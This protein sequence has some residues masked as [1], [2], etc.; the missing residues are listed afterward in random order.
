MVLLCLCVCVW[1]NLHT[2]VVKVAPQAT[3]KLPSI[4][5]LSH[6]AIRCVIIHSYNSFSCFSLADDDR[7]CPVDSQHNLILIH[8]FSLSFALVLHLLSLF[9]SF[10]LV[11]AYIWLTFLSSTN[12]SL[13]VRQL[14]IYM[15]IKLNNKVV[16]FV[17]VCVCL[18]FVLST[19]SH[20][21][22]GG[23]N[24]KEPMSSSSSSSPPMYHNNGAWFLCVCLWFH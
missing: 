8:I 2:R 20:V 18:Y 23:P 6:K 13:L 17:C 3:N 15:S 12:L 9:L 16:L 11:T 7:W 19:N 5:R 21:L 22:V 14:L 4:S 24:T 10:F 1:P